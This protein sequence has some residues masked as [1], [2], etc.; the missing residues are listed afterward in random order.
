MHW[1]KAAQALLLAVGTVMLCAGVL[2]GEAAAVLSKAI[3][4]CLECVGIG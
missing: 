4:L 2:R 1:K 3:R